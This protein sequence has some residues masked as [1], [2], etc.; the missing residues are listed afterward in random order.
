MQIFRG[1]DIGTAKITAEEMDGVPHHM[2]DIKEPWG[3]MFTTSLIDLGDYPVEFAD[4]P[5][6]TASIMSNYSCF[7]QRIGDYSKSKVGTTYLARPVNTNA[8]GYISIMAIGRW[9]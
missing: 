1:L 2:I 6:V 7:I 9:K 5:T 3:S 8:L 4:V